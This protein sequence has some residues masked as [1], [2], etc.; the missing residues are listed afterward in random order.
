[1]HY[2]PILDQENH[3]ESAIKNVIKRSIEESPAQRDTD[4]QIDTSP[5]PLLH[6]ADCPSLPTVVVKTG[7]DELEKLSSY[8]STHVIEKNGAGEMK[9]SELGFATHR[10]YTDWLHLTEEVGLFSFERLGSVRRIRGQNA[11]VEHL[12]CGEDKNCG[13]LCE[14]GEKLHLPSFLSFFFPYF[15]PSFLNFVN[16]NQ[17]SNEDSSLLDGK[18]PVFATVTK[19]GSGSVQVRCL[20]NHIE[21]QP[22]PEPVSKPDLPE[23][24]LLTGFAKSAES[25]TS[26]R[27]SFLRKLQGFTP[28]SAT[29][30]EVLDR[31]LVEISQL[32]DQQE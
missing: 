27:H 3:I 6:K 17:F 24:Q 13:E 18:C 23:T 15:L 8:L 31:K 32:M 22:P 11:S 30:N 19:F 25:W 28:K 2:R 7:A 4:D 21:H 5:P 26:T 14:L 1:M 20:L 29:M 12:V 9:I 16:L 10:A